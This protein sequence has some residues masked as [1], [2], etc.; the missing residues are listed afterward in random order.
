MYL[1]NCRLTIYVFQGKGE[2]YL[3]LEITNR[4]SCVSC[5]IWI[6][7]DLGFLKE[8]KSHFSYDSSIDRHPVDTQKFE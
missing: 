4:G 2:V 5:L 8:L 6:F 7:V 3:E 1:S